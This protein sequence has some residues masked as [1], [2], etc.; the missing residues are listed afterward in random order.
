[1]TPSLIFERYKQAAGS[2]NRVGKVLHTHRGTFAFLH[3]RD[4]IEN[5]GVWLT[6][7]QKLTTTAEGSAKKRTAVDVSKMNPNIAG[8]APVRQALSD[9]NL[10]G[11][12]VRIGRAPITGMR[13]NIIKGP[14]KG[15]EGRVKD[16][17]GEQVR[18]ELS[19]NNKLVTVP[20]AQL[21]HQSV[22]ALKF[23]YLG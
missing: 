23:L 2:Q 20:K 22:L 19:S 12:P 16:A 18:V 11:A 10:M 13:V 6:Y 14:N 4:Q 9:Q 3:S 5:G 1:M 15:K 17:H 21:R 8:I 7:A